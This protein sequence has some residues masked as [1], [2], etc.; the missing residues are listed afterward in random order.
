MF[1]LHLIALIVIVLVIYKNAIKKEISY[2]YCA[3]MFFGGCAAMSSVLEFDF[4]PLLLRFFQ[5]DSP[6]IF[7]V[8]L[9]SHFLSSFGYTFGPYSYLIFGLIYSGQFRDV[10]DKYER[11]ILCALFIPVILSYAINFSDIST[12]LLY[13]YFGHSKYIWF[14]PL[15]VV[16]YVIFSSSMLIISILNEKNERVRSERLINAII[17]VPSTTLIMISNYILN[18]L[19]I[20]SALKFNVWIVIIMLLLF[21][22]FAL[23][24]DIMGV[25]IKFEQTSFNNTLR[26]I[27]SG[28][29]ILNHTIKNEIAK[30]CLCAE[31]INFEELEENLSKEDFDK[32][33]GNINEILNSSE[34]LLNTVSKV[35]KLISEF[36]ITEAPHDL[37][38]II[39]CSITDASIVIGSKN[40]KINKKFCSDIEVL[41]DFEVMR[42]A[43]YNVLVNAI[44]AIGQ[45]G[46]IDISISKNANKLVLSVSDTGTG[47]PDENLPHLA[48]PFFTTKHLNEHLGLG[49][50]Y[51]YN[52]ITR[53]NGTIQFQSRVNEGSTVYINFS[54]KKITGLKSLNLANDIRL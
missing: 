2:W 43:I 5:N 34:S 10:I 6:L 44:E 53:H 36:E 8:S 52:A 42:K 16:P 41:C 13:K 26:S 19:G 45:K 35:Q 33:Y 15:W 17:V 7:S 49:L 23:K 14:L 39:D 12:S 31:T 30:I 3:V 32:V 27:T 40:I 46:E 47:I 21:V 18:A 50:T 1:V 9:V 37:S 4:K 54:N 29:S 20:K 28:T 25:K 24:Y 48:E 51:T 22:Y 11:R 38:K